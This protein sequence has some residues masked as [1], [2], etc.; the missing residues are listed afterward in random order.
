MM[1]LRKRI[2]ETADKGS[3]IVLISEDLDEIFHMADRIA[4]IYEGKI[5]GVFDKTAVT[6]EEVGILMAGGSL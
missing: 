1:F 5:R 6:K 4:V 2:I 3:A